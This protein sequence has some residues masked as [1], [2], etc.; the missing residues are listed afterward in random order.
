MSIQSTL[1]LAGA[2]ALSGAATAQDAAAPRAQAHSLRTAVG[3]A[4]ADLGLRGG[5]LDY[6][7]DLL[8]GELSYSPALGRA[9]ERT[10]SLTYRVESIDRG[11]EPLFRAGTAP[12]EPTR[13]AGGRS[14]SSALGEG[15]TERIHLRPD[16]VEVT[17]VVDERPGGDGDL[18]VRARLGG[19]LTPDRVGRCDEGLA[20]ALG[21]LTCVTV[22]GVTGVD[23]LGQTVRGAMEL[24]DD[25]LTMSL[26][27]SFLETAA[28]PIVL[29]P[30][31]GT[32]SEIAGGFDEF[33]P[34]LIYDPA[35]DRFLAVWSRQF[36]ST[37]LA[38]RG[39]FIDASGNPDGGVIFIHAGG[40]NLD[41]TVGYVAETERF[42]V[43]YR[44]DDDLHCKVLSNTGQVG[45]E[46][47]V[48][49][50]TNVELDPSV[51]ANTAGGDD[52]IMTWRELTGGLDFVRSALIDTSP[53][54]LDAT[55]GAPQIVEIASGIGRVSMSRSGNEGGHYLVAWERDFVGGR[56]I[57][58]AVIALDAQVIDNNIPITDDL[59]D[60]DES[61]PVCDGDG[62]NFLVAYA[63]G[64]DRDIAVT[65]VMFSAPLGDAFVRSQVV[66]EADVN[67]DEVPTSMAFAGESFLL[68]FI[69][70]V[71]LS[72]FSATIQP[73]DVFSGAACGFDESVTGL[74]S[75]GSIVVAT[76]H[77]TDPGATLDEAMLLDNVEDPA[78]E[79][80]LFAVRYASVDGLVSNLGG[81]CAGG[82]IAASCAITP[83]GNFAVRLQDA[84]PLEIAL[85]VVSESS[86]NQSCG[87][88]V[89]V[90]NP[91]DGLLLSAGVVNTDGTESIN[92]PISSSSALDGFTFLAQWFVTSTSPG[93]VALNGSFTDALEITLE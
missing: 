33:D 53:S 10:P 54:T 11:G 66:V 20:F 46:A 42:V 88:C 5:G 60:T 32:P 50:S 90:A 1:A 91:F 77:Q 84:A 47:S 74:E 93:C 12:A 43:A 61:F 92:I 51:A 79:G 58:G 29:D 35:T 22:G 4:E 49:V 71:F 8:P 69:D 41:V 2:L 23:A 48:A 75:S 27:H 63:T 18:V 39:A 59:D 31:I 67:D 26:P 37:D 15:L 9:V 13:D 57:Q 70:Q 52:T 44:R 36:A 76:R 89:L 72:S 73:L 25:L 28:Y 55:V 65:P 78:G 82:S 34:D 19:G 83:N 17:Y 16:G 45:P 62:T 14:A 24:R 68:G 3:L 7:V 30:V 85:L 87:G 64:S 6:R 56:D 38:V 86:L 81:G 21:D 80:D 40:R